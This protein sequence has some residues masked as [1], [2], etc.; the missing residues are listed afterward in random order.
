LIRRQAPR[1]RLPPI[2]CCGI[3]KPG[4]ITLEWILDTHPH[5]DHFSAAGYLKDMTGAPTASGDRVTEVQKIWKVLYHL[6]RDLPDRRVAMGSSVCGW[7]T[8]RRWRD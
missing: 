6:A 7:R 4:G 8:I 5:A 2:D 1:E 3:S